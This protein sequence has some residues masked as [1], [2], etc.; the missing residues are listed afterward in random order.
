M[1]GL[2]YTQNLD[3]CWMFEQF[4]SSRA[5]ALARQRK[6]LAACI[7][8]HVYRILQIPHGNRDFFMGSGDVW[9]LRMR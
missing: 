8:A 5:Q 2:S 1:C 7:L 3:V 9:Y 6:E 4:D